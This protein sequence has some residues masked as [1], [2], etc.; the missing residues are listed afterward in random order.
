MHDCR[1]SLC[2]SPHFENDDHPGEC[3]CDMC[4]PDHDWE[5][6]NCYPPCE[7]CAETLLEYWREELQEAA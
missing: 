4:H 7:G 3:L 5:M 6:W 2:D 1:R